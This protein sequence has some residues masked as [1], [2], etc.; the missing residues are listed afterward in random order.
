M[1]R[2]IL[3]IKETKGPQG[4][5][6]GELQISCVTSFTL[7]CLKLDKNLIIIPDIN[8]NS[9]IA[10]TEGLIKAYKQRKLS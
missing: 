7:L 3:S 10:N 2:Q 4:T 8:Y 9:K 1:T 5:I 6:Y